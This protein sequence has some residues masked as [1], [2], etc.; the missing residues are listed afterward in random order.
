MKTQPAIHMASAKYYY[1]DEDLG[2]VQG[3]VT[4]EELINL[5][6]KTQIYSFTKIAREGTE[7]WIPYEEEL[8]H[9]LF[10]KDS[11]FELSPSERDTIYKQI[12]R[13]VGVLENESLGEPE[14]RFLQAWEQLKDRKFGEQLLFQNSVPE[15]TS[16]A[17]VSSSSG[18]RVANALRYSTAIYA[19][20]NNESLE[21]IEADVDD[22][23]D[24]FLG[25]D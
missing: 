24:S 7:N 21:A 20:Q 1:V 5:R 13:L 11:F 18:A 2:G 10:F 3:P 22:M 6:E 4:T 16:G 12:D 14:I 8:V 9:A 15:S 17:S 25:E 23:A 19:M